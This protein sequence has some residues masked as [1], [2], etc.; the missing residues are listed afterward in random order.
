M[1]PLVTQHQE[2]LTRLCHQFRVRR[3]AVFGSAASD[4]FQPAASDLDF[5]VE[6][7]PQTPR[8]HTDAYF[9][10]WEALQKLFERR[11]DLVEREA[12]RN[13]YFSR[14]LDETAAELY[15]A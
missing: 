2:I 4:Q 11:V 13:P 3:L 12:V 1:D 6:F 7:L 9:G 8:E 14:T 5:V 15:A 10:L